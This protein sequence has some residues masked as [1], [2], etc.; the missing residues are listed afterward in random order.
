M[1]SSLFPSF[2]HIRPGGLVPDP[3]KRQFQSDISAGR[4]PRYFSAA[5]SDPQRGLY[6]SLQHSWHERNGRFTTT[7][8][9][10]LTRNLFWA[11]CP[12]N[13]WLPYYMMDGD[14]WLTRTL[15]EWLVRDDLESSVP[16]SLRD[17]QRRIRAKR[18]IRPEARPGR[19]CG[20]TLH[21]YDRTYTCK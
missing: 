6:E 19:V 12:S 7:V 9:A 17:H 16:W 18:K 5:P 1:S 8:K 2:P 20:K 15:G 13:E 3:T 4:V 21:R 14:K 10:T 11:I